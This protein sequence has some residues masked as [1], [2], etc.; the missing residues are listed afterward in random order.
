MLIDLERQDL[1]MTAGAS[2]ANAP[3]VTLHQFSSFVCLLYSLCTLARSNKLAHICW[4]TSTA[5]LRAERC[6]ICARRRV[7][8]RVF[9]EGILRLCIQLL[10]LQLLQVSVQLCKLGVLFPCRF[11]SS[12]GQVLVAFPLALGELLQ[13]GILGCCS[14]LATR[15]TPRS[16]DSWLTLH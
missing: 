14:F 7:N 13:Q 5:H 3:T 10:L 12:G 8:L 15:S 6:N 11:L 16:G 9:A 2:C 4:I 1:F